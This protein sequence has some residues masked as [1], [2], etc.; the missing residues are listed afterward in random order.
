MTYYGLNDIV[1]KT[2]LIKWEEKKQEACRWNRLAMSWNSWNC[3]GCL[4]YHCIHLHFSWWTD[5]AEKK[6]SERK[7]KRGE[8]TIY[9][10]LAVLKTVNKALE[11]WCRNEDLVEIQINPTFL[12]YCLVMWNKM[13]ITLWSSNPT[14]WYLLYLRWFS[15]N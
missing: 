9:F 8:G 13:D 7:I 14:S 2:H 10:W 15:D 1:S 5:K 11:N 3:H 12:K 6:I 4:F